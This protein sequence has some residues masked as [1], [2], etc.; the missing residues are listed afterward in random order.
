VERYFY[1][2]KLIKFLK[3]Y[4]SLVFPRGSPVHTKHTH[5]G[6]LR[7]LSIRIKASCVNCIFPWIRAY[8]AHYLTEGLQFPEWSVDWPPEGW[9]VDWPPVVRVVDWPPVVRVVDEAPDVVGVE[10]EAPD[11]VRVR[12]EAPVV[13]RVALPEHDPPVDGG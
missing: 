3:K 4:I 13:V 10:D 9:L 6:I 7:Q 11:A 1:L 2:L 8:F 5:E 12:D